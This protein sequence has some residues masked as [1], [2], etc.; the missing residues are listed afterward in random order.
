MDGPY[1]LKMTFTSAVLAEGSKKKNTSMSSLGKFH[2][3]L[4]DIRNKTLVDLQYNPIIV[5]RI[6]RI[7]RETEREIERVPS[8]Q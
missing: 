7:E 6:N 8:V 3:S 4:S 5:G 2:I 1:Y